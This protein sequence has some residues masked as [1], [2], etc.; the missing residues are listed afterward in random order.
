[1]ALEKNKVHHIFKLADTTVETWR[2]DLRNSLYAILID[3]GWIKKEGEEFYSYP[4]DNKIKIQIKYKNSSGNYDFWF[5]IRSYSTAG[6]YVE[7]SSFIIASYSLEVAQAGLFLNYIVNSK[8]EVGIGL[9]SL[10]NG[11][12]EDKFFFLIGLDKKNNAGVFIFPK[13][14]GTTYSFM[15]LGEGIGS[16]S[17]R[18]GQRLDTIVPYPH[19][20]SNTILYKCINYIS[21]ELFD[22]I[23]GFYASP[24]N[25]KTLCASTFYI[26]DSY[27]KVIGN[28]EENVWKTTGNSGTDNSTTGDPSLLS[29][30]NL[31]SFSKCLKLI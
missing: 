26:N 23:F 30:E 17:D 21:G 6:S 5:V 4:K 7:Q 18:A 25:N 15:S 31:G 3:E 9:S 2:D 19:T 13:T 1:M 28:N 20:F 12:Y 27:Y 24:Y 14:D 10:V 11:A 22:N 16:K 29:N 8:G